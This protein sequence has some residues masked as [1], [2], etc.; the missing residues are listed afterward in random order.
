MA[1]IF[2]YYDA[3]R[4]RQ[5][6]LLPRRRLAFSVTTIDRCYAILRFSAGIA[7]GR[8]VMMAA[9]IYLWAI[10]HFPTRRLYT[11]FFH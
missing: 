7:P 2:R 6:C 10:S 5:R 11:I 9:Q 4:R 3:G 1:H 8:C